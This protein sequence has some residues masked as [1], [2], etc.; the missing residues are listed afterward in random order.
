V[1]SL[2]TSQIPKINTSITSTPIK[3][4][5]RGLFFMV[6]SFTDQWNLREIQL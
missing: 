5:L 1:V 6:V 3:I 4:H 2:R